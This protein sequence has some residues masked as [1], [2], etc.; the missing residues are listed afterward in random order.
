MGQT[1]KR[2][3]RDVVA[4]YHIV[5]PCSFL[6]A[7]IFSKIIVHFHHESATFSRIVSH[8]LRAS[9]ILIYNRIIGH[10][11]QK[12]VTF[13]RIVS[14]T[15]RASHIL[16]YNRI[17]G[18]Y[19]QKLVTFSRIVSHT[20]RTSHIITR[21]LTHLGRWPYS[22]ENARE[23]PSLHLQLEGRHPCRH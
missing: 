18:H 3:D 5:A 1:K 19:H 17:I 8:T 2:H 10:Y 7:T 12:L 16:I 6:E 4:C 13:S 11:H 23:S 15:L 14:H 20:L 21:C 22:R 9:H